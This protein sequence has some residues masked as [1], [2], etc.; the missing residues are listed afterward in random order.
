[1]DPGRL[2]ETGELP[3]FD[4]PQQGASPSGSHS[5]GLPSGRGYLSPHCLSNLHF[6]S[7]SPVNFKR[8]DPP[9]LF[10]SFSM[11]PRTSTLF[12]YQV[13]EMFLLSK[14]ETFPLMNLSLKIN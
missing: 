13:R 4:V 11:P 3:H 5:A 7:G 12:F 1:M 14:K 8:L 2:Q 10:P 9:K 6:L